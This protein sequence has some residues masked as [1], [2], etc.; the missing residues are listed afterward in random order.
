MSNSVVQSPIVLERK[1]RDASGAGRIGF[2]DGV[3]VSEKI[4]SL[5]VADYD[6]LR[7]NLSASRYRVGDVVTVLHPLYSGVFEIESGSVDDGG[8]RISDGGLLMASRRVNGGI[9][10][11]WFGVV[12][13]GSDETPLFLNMINALGDLNLN[14]VPIDITNGEIG[15]VGIIIPHTYRLRF[16]GGKIRSLARRGD[17]GAA[18]AFNDAVKIYCPIV[19]GD[20][21]H[22]F[23][24]SS[25]NVTNRPGTDAPFLFGKNDGVLNN[26]NP[27]VSV[28]WFGLNGIGNGEDIPALNVASI[29]VSYGAFAGSSSSALYGPNTLYFPKGAYNSKN[30]NGLTWTITSG[31]RCLGEGSGSHMLSVIYMANTT[32]ATNSSVYIYGHWADVT[33]GAQFFFDK[34]GFRYISVD[35]FSAGS[36]ELDLSVIEVRANSAQLDCKIT[37]CWF[38]G[39]PQKGAVIKW[40]NRYDN[41]GNEINTGSDS[42]GLIVK[43][44]GANNVY[45][46]TSC[47]V[48]CYGRGSGEVYESNVFGF[49]WDLGACRNYS[50]HSSKKLSVVL[51]GGR[52]I[53][54]AR[55]DARVEIQG[56]PVVT[57][58]KISHCE[59][60]LTGGVKITNGRQTF[61]F[62][63]SVQ[64]DN[65]IVR[66]MPGT[67]FEGSHAIMNPMFDM[68]G[69]DCSVFIN[70]LDIYGDFSS[71]GAVGKNLSIV[72]RASAVNSGVARLRFDNS[73]IESS[74]G[75]ESWIA[76][77]GANADFQYIYARSNTLPDGDSNLIG[78]GLGNVGHY[79]IKD[80][81]YSTSSS[82]S[83][84]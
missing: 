67:V 49:R 22:I 46:V 30:V 68:T 73:F 17:E 28:R 23:T 34:L 56:E 83:E 16:D 69:F 3:T 79:I 38:L 51:D 43:T 70:G 80:N 77:D 50:Q 62:C 82:V 57:K 60:T 59:L 75:L 24:W 6:E 33:K 9:N 13:D 37:D 25:N 61:N 53:G 12:A 20:C 26:S 15:L 11:G 71:D 42:D 40:G 65:S 35:P 1:L 36:G 72:N 76:N 21:Q 54:F 66:V 81:I 78:S 18:F 39:T 8:M 45:D 63:F 14:D 52:V 84:N 7:A 2:S 19:A 64:P 44:T 58:H 74:S 31:T 48:K 4:N 41:D 55:N 32:T 5:R 10:P 47:L 27:R 29:S